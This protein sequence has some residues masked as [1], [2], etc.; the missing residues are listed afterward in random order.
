MGNNGILNKNWKSF[1]KELLSNEQDPN[2]RPRSSTRIRETITFLILIAFH[3]GT[4][5][6]DTK[7]IQSQPHKAFHLLLKLLPITQSNLGP[8][9]NEEAENTFTTRSSRA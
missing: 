8:I 6:K 5:K 2:E 9:M 7:H 3:R 1:S 4:V